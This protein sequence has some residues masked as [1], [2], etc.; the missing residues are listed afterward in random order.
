MN[1]LE[2]FKAFVKT[3]PGLISYVRNGSMTWQKFYELWYL[4]GPNHDEWNKYESIKDDNASK[5]S[6][7]G[8]NDIFNMLKKVDMNTVRQGINGLQKAIGLIQEITNK[9]DSTGTA[10]VK[11]PYKPRPMFRKFE[12]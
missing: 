10:D 12:D 1:K 11:E 3:K 2:E 5:A 4:Y 9:S 8:L 7:F 6:L